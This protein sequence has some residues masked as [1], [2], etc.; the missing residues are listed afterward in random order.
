MKSLSIAAAAAFV[1]VLGIQGASAV[2]QPP[3]PVNN[4]NDP[5]NKPYEASVNVGCASASC[6]ASFSAVTAPNL[7]IQH[8][9]C[10]LYVSPAPSYIN[11]EVSGSG[12]QGANWVKAS[13]ISNDL[14]L[15]VINDSIELFLSSNV[16][17]VIDI[18]T[19]TSISNGHCTI[20]GY[21]N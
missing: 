21:H 14:T 3:L 7:L 8:V 6:E 2:S 9:S 20:S 12:L 10:N 1:Y 5:V 16:A 15:Y 11:V 19:D 18:G 4:V 13:P 17:P